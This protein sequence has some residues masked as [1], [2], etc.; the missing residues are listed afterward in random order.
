MGFTGF[1]WDISLAAV[2]ATRQFTREHGDIIAHHIEGV[3]WAEAF[4]GQSLPP[5]IVEEWEGKK[6]GTPPQGKIY[7]AIS[8]GRGD[9]KV[10]EKAG[11]LPPDLRGCSYDDPR[12]KQA[13]LRY[14]EQTIAFF[15][16]QYLAIGIEANEILDAGRAKWEAY[17]GLHRFIYA[18]LKRRH[19]EL[20]VFASFTLHNLYK[21][22]GAML[23]EWS[24]LMPYNDLVAVSYYPFFMG[25]SQRLEAL[26]WCVETFASAAKPMAMVETNDAAE[27]TPLPKLNLVI[28]GTPARQRAYYEK[29]LRLAQARQFAFV[30]SFVHQDYD[31]LWEK[32]KAHSPEFFI[33]WRDCGFWD[34]DGQPRPS[35]QVWQDYFA[36][37]LADASPRIPF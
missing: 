14:C 28:E 7:V 24:K 35:F 29:L 15:H 13:Y 1:V 10:A 36:L 19:P 16:P 33:A 5:K 6:K 22:K 32:I 2:T 4:G 26:D 8:P 9:L 17:M 11:P 3:P 21:K 23:E 12:V 30:I 31:A 20:S 34:Q 37:P 25:E 18:E 27:R